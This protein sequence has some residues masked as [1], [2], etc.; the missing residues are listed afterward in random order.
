MLFRFWLVTSLI[1]AF[2][3]YCGALGIF[4]VPPG[5]QSALGGQ[6]L[7]PSFFFDDDAGRGR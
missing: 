6:T 1:V 3:A 4:P 2:V 5:G 7:G